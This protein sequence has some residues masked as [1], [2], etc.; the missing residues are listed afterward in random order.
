MF[1]YFNVSNYTRVE[2]SQLVDQHIQTSLIF[3]KFERSRW[4]NLFSSNLGN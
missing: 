1:F 4:L 2:L 3:A